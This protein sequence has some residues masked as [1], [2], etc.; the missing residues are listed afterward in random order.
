MKSFTLFEKLMTKV[1]VFK[2]ND[3]SKCF[4]KV[5]VF[6]IFSELKKVPNLR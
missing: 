4:Q 3:K 2:I 5:N 1:S 6:L